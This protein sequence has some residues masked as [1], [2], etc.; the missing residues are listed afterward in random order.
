M[1]I[2]IIAALIGLLIGFYRG[3]KIHGNDTENKGISILGKTASGIGIFLLIGLVSSLVLSLIVKET[4][5]RVKVETGRINIHAMSDG[6]GIQGS[7]FLGSGH[8]GTTDY[9]YYYESMGSGGFK[10][11]KVPVDNATIFEDEKGRA[12]MIKYKMAMP[13][14]HWSNGWA[15]LTSNN[16]G[17]S[18]CGCSQG[19]VEFHIP[20]GS[21]KHNYNLDLK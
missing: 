8:I 12:Y 1:N 9:Y 21:V 15:I 13:K 20:S 11:G 17:S 6:S 2:I 19:P 10:Q 18:N 14:D 3:Q 4:V 5:V 7:F 16:N